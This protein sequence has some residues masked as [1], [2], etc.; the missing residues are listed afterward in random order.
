MRL[1]TKPHAIR[2]QRDYRKHLA[3]T[4]I[5]WLRCPCKGKWKQG[6]EVILL[7]LH[8]GCVPL[9]PKSL[10]QCFPAHFLFDL[11]GESFVK[12]P[13]INA[14][15]WGMELKQFLF[16]FLNRWA[17]WQPLAAAWR[18]R[19]MQY[20]SAVH[21]LSAFS[22]HLLSSQFLQCALHVKL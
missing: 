10:D 15:T 14:M 6:T 3:H 20:T 19:L 7:Q 17:D 1:S 16:D 8:L 9:L 4:K 12:L 11:F 13:G 2:W 18:V 5:I 22:W 21:I